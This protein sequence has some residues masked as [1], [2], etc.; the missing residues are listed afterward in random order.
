[1]SPQVNLPLLICA[2]VDFS[3]ATLAG[4]PTFATCASASTQISLH[5]DRQV[6]KPLH[7]CGVH[8]SALRGMAIVTPSA[9][10]SSA[11]MTMAI[12]MPST[13]L[14]EPGQTCRRCVH[15]TELSH[16]KTIL[17]WCTLQSLTARNTG[18]LVLHGSKRVVCIVS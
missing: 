12:V 17:G 5:T 9:T 18:I 15:E 8:A 3:N 6:Q 1:M 16:L 4:P 7:I 13:M 11:I 14:Q 2:S 10:R